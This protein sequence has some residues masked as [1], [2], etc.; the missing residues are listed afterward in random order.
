MR[1]RTGRTRVALLS[2]CVVVFLAGAG[3]SQAAAAPLS[4]K[5]KVTLTGP[6]RT[7][8]PGLLGLNGVNTTGPQWNDAALD[9]VLKKFAP[10]VIRYPGGNAANYWSWQTGWFQPGQWPGEPGEPVNDTIGV[11]A[12]A[13]NATAALP[14]FNLNT[15]TYDGAI[16]TAAQ[17][18]TMLAGQLDFL[19]AAAAQGLPVK[20][21]ELGNELYQNGWSNNPPN[22]HD[23]DWA[24]RFPTAAD[25]ATQMNAWITAIHSAFPAAQVAAVGADAEDIPDISQRRATWNAGVLPVLKGE[26][27]ITL[28]ENLYLYDV[29]PAATVLA[30]PY[31]HFQKLKAHDLALFG[32]Y[33]LPVWI[34]E[35]NL[36]DVTP[37]QA[38]QGTWL[39]GLFVAEQA[40]LFV[41]DPAITY[42]GLNATV[43]NESAAIFA[44][45]SG[46][47]SGGPKTV[48][49]ALTAAG[50]TLSVIQAAFH[51]ATAAQPLSF[52]GGPMLGTTGAPALIGERL[53]TASGPELVLVN[54]SAQPVT[55]NLAAIFPGAFTVTQ[56][57]APAITTK[58]TG[59]ASTQ[60]SSSSASGSVQIKPY[61]LADVS[62]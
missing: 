53:T 32:S 19:H 2:G 15:V 58:V 34:T 47:G 22:P 37:G 59:P 29:S 30:M 24:K 39:H 46:F 10:G 35:F 48:P 44:G 60:T 1:K 8:T 49:L 45:S 41:G 26:N 62:G 25:Y 6:A 40:L 31:L 27:A 21:V 57:T 20:M 3:A 52:S 14:L 54:L 23:M 51:R 50:T 33:G 18:T 9:A 36:V 11:F 55:L 61:A 17:N 38:F 16:G 43:G 28:H 56:V 5:V 42:A 12:A 4:G 7:V 13:V